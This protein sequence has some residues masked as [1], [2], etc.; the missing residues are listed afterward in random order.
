MIYVL[1]LLFHLLIESDVN[2]LKP[3]VHYC[4]TF[5]VFFYFL[6][7]YLANNSLVTCVLLL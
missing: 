4:N 5:I 6:F 1:M 2:E 7:S 3:A